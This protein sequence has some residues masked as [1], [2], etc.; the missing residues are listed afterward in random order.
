MTQSMPSM[1]EEPRKTTRLTTRATL[2]SCM[3]SREMQSGMKP[4]RS[5]L[6][7]R[8]TKPTR[9]TSRLSWSRQ[10]KNLRSSE[11]RDFRSCTHASGSSGKLSSTHRAWPSSRIDFEG[12]SQKL[13]FYLLIQYTQT[14]QTKVFKIF[15][16]FKF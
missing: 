1:R 12:K 9:R 3:Q 15:Y 5:M 16:S 6:W 13:M 14:L 11:T 2:V 7:P 8:L 4:M 10:M